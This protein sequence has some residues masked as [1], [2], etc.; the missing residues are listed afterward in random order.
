MEINKN[1][2]YSEVKNIRDVISFLLLRAGQPGWWFLQC[3]CEKGGGGDRGRP[4]PHEES[5]R[6][7]RRLRLPSAGFGCV[8]PPR[9]FKEKKK[10]EEGRVGGENKKAQETGGLRASRRGPNGTRGNPSVPPSAA[11]FAA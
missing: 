3:P 2:Y 4:T 11:D 5:A 8:F 1:Y 6:R 7:R 10:K 9:G